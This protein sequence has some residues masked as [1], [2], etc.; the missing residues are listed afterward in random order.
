MSQEQKRSKISVLA[1]YGV[2]IG[3]NSDSIKY[4]AMKFACS[5]G[6]V[7]MAD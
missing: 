4:R 7:A 6:F 3:N 1:M 2:A 5:V